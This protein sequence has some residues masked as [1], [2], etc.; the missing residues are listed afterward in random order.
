MRCFKAS[1][2]LRLEETL[3]KLLYVKGS[4]GGMNGPLVGMVAYVNYRSQISDFR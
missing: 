3:S 1:R 4:I 2:I